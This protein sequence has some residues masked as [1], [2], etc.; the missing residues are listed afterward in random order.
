MKNV[1]I[2]LALLA[3]TALGLTGGYLI[4]KHL[5]EDLAAR[6]REASPSDAAE[7]RIASDAGGDETRPEPT[8]AAASDADE[9]DEE[10]EYR[11]LVAKRALTDNCLVC[12]EEAMISGQRLTAAQWKAEV[13][14]MIGWGAVLP[15]MDR[16]PVEEYLVRHYGEDVPVPP[17]GRVALADVPTFETP[18]DPV[19][20]TTEADVA[21]GAQLYR[22]V[23]AS[24]HGP[25][26][27]GTELG[28]A[29]VDRAVLTH[30]GAFHEVVEKGRRKMP[31]TNGVLKGDQS[32]DILA[33]LRG[34]DAATAGET[35]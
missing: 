14:K 20:G 7:S 6:T 30:A 35:P 28:P 33:W 26:A 23:C 27:L 10:A 1:M 11:D 15:D 16:G 32:R 17:P 5:A 21:Q 19:E 8:P 22:I 9:D 29:L 2:A 4:Q 34:L 12:H 24:C 25:S 31:S 18:G 3:I 13:D